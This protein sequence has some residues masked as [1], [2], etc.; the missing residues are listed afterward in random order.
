MRSDLSLDSNSWDLVITDDI[1]IVENAAM[2]SQDSKFSLQLIQGEV[3][4]DTRL[5][6]P[7]LTDMV[8]PQV[9]I[10][11]RKQILRDTIMRTPGAVELTSLDVA[12][13]NQTGIASCTFEGITDNG[14][15]FG[16]SVGEVDIP[17]VTDSGIIAEYDYITG[18]SFGLRLER[19][20]EATYI[21]DG[22]LKY[23]GINIPRFE[24]EGLLL[25]NQSTN[26]V[27]NSESTSPTWKPNNA[28][29]VSADIISPDDT[30]SGVTR[31]ASS[32]VANKQTG[33][34]ITVP[35]SGL[36]VGGYCSFS[37]FAKADNHNLI[38]LRWLGGSGGVSNRYL[39]VDLSTGEVG[40]NTI[41]I[42]KT[43]PM[44]NGWWRIVAVT[45]I[46]GDLTGGY[47][48]DP[49]VE[50]ISSLS[51]RR[52]PAVTLDNG[53]G[54]YLY[55]PQLEATSLNNSYIPTE[56]SELTRGADVL[57]VNEQGAEWIYREYIPL[58]LE[59]TVKELVKYDGTISPYGH[60]QKLKVWSREPTASER[61]VL[62]L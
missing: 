19:A 24:K 48:A 43:I 55:G 16:S 60:L 36:S 13:D 26:L 5:G 3:F 28:T 49:G 32:G 23:A 52:R 27:P 2:T 46:D 14:G 8:N 10:A 41:F 59:S 31:L 54:V 11:A 12:V 37:V 25:E 40:P 51:D 38:Q 4:D 35:V 57:S 29:A 62:G 53:A 15:I 56:G 39:N 21:K 1:S 30:T 47:S 9:S 22:L 6:V 61:A 42:A 34:A 20:S 58:G 50:L 7:W 17:S 45:P 33:S 44:N 18:K